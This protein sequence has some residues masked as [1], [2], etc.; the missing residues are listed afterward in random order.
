MPMLEYRWYKEMA[1]FMLTA[2]A[3]NM[4][5][6]NYAYALK[7]ILKRFSQSLQFLQFPQV[8]QPSQFSQAEQFSQ[9]LQALQS[10]Q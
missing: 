9:P 5:Q 7:W 10:S 4:H 6:T 8:L 2:Y 3:L 1:S